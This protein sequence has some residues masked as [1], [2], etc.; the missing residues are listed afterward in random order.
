MLALVALLSALTVTMSVSALREEFFRVFAA[1]RQNGIEYYIR[2]ENRE[3]LYFHRIT[4]GCVPEDFEMEW[5]HLDQRDLWSTYHLCYTH[6]DGRTFSV[7][8]S[9]E[10]RYSGVF[11]DVESETVT[12]QGDEAQ[13]QEDGTYCCLFW[14]HGPNIMTLTSD[15]MTREEIMK[16]A[17][18]IQW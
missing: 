6:A 11:G 14:I 13:L 9:V 10:E 17:E 5:E 2:A 12:V 16:I 15:G 1:V 3:A 7:S 8:Q 18:Q 4:L